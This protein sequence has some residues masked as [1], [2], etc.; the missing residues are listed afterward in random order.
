MERERNEDQRN[1]GGRVAGING[2]FLRIDGSRICK[3]RGT[4]AMGPWLRTLAG[5]GL[6]R[7]L[8]SYEL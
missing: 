3:A 1:E 2:I 7:W 8:S 6:E 5:W 4:D